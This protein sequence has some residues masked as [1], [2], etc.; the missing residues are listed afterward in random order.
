MTRPGTSLV[1]IGVSP[2]IAIGPA[3]VLEKTDFT[4][5]RWEI[6]GGGTAAEVRRFRAAVAASAAQLRAFRRRLARDL[7]P[8][9][10]YL[11]DAHL[12]MLRDR[13]FGDGVARLIREDRVNAEWAVQQMIARFRAA[14]E[15]IGDAYL[16]E[17]AGDMEDIGER[18]LRNLAGA[19][20]ERVSEIPEGVIV[21]ARDLA[22]SDTAQMRRER[23]LGFA[24]DMGGKTSHTA[25]VARSLEIP[26]VVGL[27]DITARVA[28]GDPL[29]LDGNTGQVHVRP[30][31]GTVAEYEALRR[32]YHRYDIELHKLRELP[33]ETLDGYRLGLEANI[34][35]PEEIPS[36]LEHGA[37]GIGLY[38]TEFIYLNRTDMPTEEEH[39]R[40]YRRLL[41]QIRPRA[42]TIR[43]FDLGG[44]KFLSQV[45]LAKEMNPALG[46]RAI[47]FC[48]REVT[49]FKTQLAGILRAS[50]HGTLRVM[51]PMVAEVSELRQAREILEEVTAD[52]ARRGVPFDPEL[53][54]GV[55]IETP[56][57]G[58]I[59]DV[60]A[61]E[62]DFFSIGTN[63]LI[64]YALAI[65]RVNEHVAYLYRPLHP[66]VLRLV[67]EVVRAAHAHGIPVAMCGEMAGEPIHTLLLIG[68]GIDSLSMNA[69]SLPRVK[70]IV[71]AS[72]LADARELAA[73][74]GQLRSA[75]E[76]EEFVKKEM[77]RRFPDDITDDGRQVCLI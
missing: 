74:A 36:V 47:R 77:R 32:R 8:Q 17:K 68:L 76:V 48:L 5:H 24:I 2:G 35:L 69:V 67:R 13:M 51:F 28:N 65:D 39:Y 66:A 54:V 45:P 16:R 14:F 15:G 53:Q 7:G 6:P 73:A 25:I 49:A 20:H 34:E 29:I 41:E 46:L 38:R 62:A 57:A 19:T 58:V 11:L 21:L 1:G 31:A 44:D 60:L 40:L 30:D 71:R 10:V 50:A 3:F 37:A 61:R 59:A 72:R 63:D 26:A 33:A 18:V 12:L 23:V 43:T 75:W 52:L 27:E 64:Q 56:A 70:K 55:M 42:A 22:P 9:H 4:A